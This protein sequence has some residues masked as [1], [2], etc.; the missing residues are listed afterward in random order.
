MR[1]RATLIVRLVQWNQ[2]NEKKKHLL[3]RTARNTP[4]G[5]MCNISLHLRHY[6]RLRYPDEPLI[7][8]LLTEKK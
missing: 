4:I 2:I 3:G 5:S 6:N 8:Q 1:V 7:L